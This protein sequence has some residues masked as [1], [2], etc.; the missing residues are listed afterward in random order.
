MLIIYDVAPLILII[1]LLFVLSSFI[2]K[3]QHDP[4]ST[5]FQRW[6]GKIL[7]CAVL[8]HGIFISAQ[9]MDTNIGGGVYAFVVITIFTVFAILAMLIGYSKANF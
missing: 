9:L 4:T 2:S 6:A 5:R 3:T 7:I 8:L 1:C